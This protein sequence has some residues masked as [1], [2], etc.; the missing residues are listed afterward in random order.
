MKQAFYILYKLNIAR[1][2]QQ[3]SFLF[4]SYARASAENFSGEGGN[5]KKTKNSKIRPKIALL[6]LYLLY[7]TMF[8]NPGGHG[9]LPPA[10]DAHVP[11]M[12]NQHGVNAP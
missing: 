10:A 5:G 7:F 2:W 12:S 1:A 9:P 3:E 6:S 8:E 11:V 4:D